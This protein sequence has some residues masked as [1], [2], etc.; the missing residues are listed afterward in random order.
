MPATPPGRTAMS[1]SRLALPRASPSTRLLPRMA[2]IPRPSAPGSDRDSP[3]DQRGYRG[4]GKID[5]FIPYLRTRL[6]ESCTNQSSLW[7]EIQAHGFTGTRSLVG[8][9]IHAHGKAHAGPLQPAPPRLPAARQLAWLVLQAEEQRTL[10]EHALWQ[11]LQQHAA[12]F[13]PKPKR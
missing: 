6:A 11:H 8:K 1:R 3:L 10:D 12:D 5:A 4:T 2:S 9:W 7:R 13:P